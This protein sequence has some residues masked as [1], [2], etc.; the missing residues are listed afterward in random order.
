MPL[1]NISGLTA[2][3]P[4]Q[5]RSAIAAGSPD[6]KQQQQDRLDT[7]RVSKA[8]GEQLETRLGVLL[9]YQEHG[10]WD[11]CGGLVGLSYFKA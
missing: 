11:W 7:S 3:S 1:H 8:A 4:D 5:L 2:A 10:S 9:G 6:K